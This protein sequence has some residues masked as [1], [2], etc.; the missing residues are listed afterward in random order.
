MRAMICAATL[1]ISAGTAFATGGIWCSADDAA[2]KF[3]VDA[4]VTTGLGGP[5][6]NFRGDLEILGRPVGDS[7]RGTGST[8]RNCG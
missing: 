1:L 7:L 8:A 2:A 3:Q 4:G 5:T 6:F